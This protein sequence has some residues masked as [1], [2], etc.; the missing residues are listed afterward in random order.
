M[1]SRNVRV[2][3]RRATLTSDCCRREIAEASVHMMGIR[4]PPGG[5][6]IGRPCSKHVGQVEFPSAV[7]ADAVRAMLDREH[8]AEVTVPAAK[9]KLEKSLQ[10]FHTSCDRWRRSEL[11]L[12][13]SHSSRERT[14][15]RARAI[16]QSAAP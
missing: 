8:T 14:L 3:D 13:S 7:E 15:A 5:M 12:A 2:R 6:K 11:P 4:S 16:E 10:Q 9:D 1:D